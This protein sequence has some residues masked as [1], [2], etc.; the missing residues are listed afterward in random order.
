MLHAPAGGGG[1]EEGGGEGA[2]R[3]THTGKRAEVP[4]PEAGLPRDARQAS[5]T[6]FCDGSPAAA[7]ETVSPMAPFVALATAASLEHTPCRARSSVMDSLAKR[8]FMPP[9]GQR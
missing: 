6:Q 3:G 9:M 5:S 1:R 4:R 2:E 7:Q 8:P